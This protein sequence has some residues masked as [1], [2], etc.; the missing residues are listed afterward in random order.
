MSLTR[1]EWEDMWK[2]IEHIEFIVKNAMNKDDGKLVLYQ[3]KKIKEQIQS[4]VGQL[5]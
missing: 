3:T 5:E 2:S 4:V 1:S